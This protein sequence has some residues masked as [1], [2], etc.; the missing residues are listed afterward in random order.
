[1]INSSSN[2]QQQRSSSTKISL[3]IR[4]ATIEDYDL[5]I[6]LWEKS[7]LPYKAKGRDSRKSITKEIVAGQGVFFIA[8]FEGKAVATVL[9]THD[10]R[11]GW[12]NRLAVTPDY[13]NQGIGKQLVVVSET[14]LKQEGI[15]IFACMIEEYN[16][17]SFKAF[18]RMGYIPFEGIHYLTKRIDP[19]I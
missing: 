11:K 5:L 17:N 2:I 16:V 15:G 13:Q 6:S 10:G 7:G 1:M 8:C 3:D 9:V 4:E 19:E 12:I 14:W 18:Q